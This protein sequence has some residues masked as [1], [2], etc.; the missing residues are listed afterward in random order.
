MYS[1]VSGYPKIFDSRNY[2]AT[3]TNPDGDA[4]KA[5]RVAKADYSAQ[6]ATFLASDARVMWAVTLSRADGRQL[7]AEYFGSFPGSSPREDDIE[8]GLM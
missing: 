6:M 3:E 7:A 5:F 4:D 2:N 8:E 1:I